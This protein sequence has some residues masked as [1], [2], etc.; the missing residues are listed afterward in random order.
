MYKLV[1]FDMDGT[2]LD[3]LT[4]LHL[5]MN[6]IL[7]KYGHAPISRDETK[8]YIGNGIPLFVQRAFEG[9]FD[10]NEDE[11]DTTVKAALK[12]FMAYYDL[13]CE[14]ST[15]PYDGIVEAIRAIRDLG[16]MTAVVSN[17]ADPAVRKLCDTY[18]KDLFDDMIGEQAGIRKK[19][20]ADMP[21]LIMKRCG[22]SKA[23]TIFVGDSNVDIKTA[24]NAGVDA[25]GV[26]WGYRDEDTLVKAGAKVIAKAPGELAGIVQ[27]EKV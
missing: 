1:I 9:R 12:D 26:L 15:K 20:A 10:V 17:K 18:F 23:E 2:I 5:S 7:E 21:E 8:S 13:H 16:L 25:I 14:D 11:A 27:S 19:P 4:D 22:A 3:T 24:C 6:H